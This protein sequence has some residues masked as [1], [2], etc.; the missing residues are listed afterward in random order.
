MCSTAPARRRGLPALA[1]ETAHRGLQPGKLSLV[2][3]CTALLQFL[4]ELSRCSRTMEPA[5]SFR[6]LSRSDETFTW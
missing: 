4:L 2:F 6:T 3:S 1:R 5:A